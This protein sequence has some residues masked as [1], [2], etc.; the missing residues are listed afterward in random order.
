[1]VILGLTFLLFQL[2]LSLALLSPSMS[3]QLLTR[4][5]SKIYWVYCEYILLEV[6]RSTLLAILDLLKMYSYCS[7]QSGTHTL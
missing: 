3:I 2:G 7:T 4:V 6:P 1:M 5:G